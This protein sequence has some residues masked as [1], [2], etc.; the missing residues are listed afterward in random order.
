ML[1]A[2]TE[3]SE[4]QVDPIWAPEIGLALNIPAENQLW[5]GWWKSKPDIYKRLQELRSQHGITVQDDL[6]ESDV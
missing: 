6:G 5:P 4:D 1:I 2:Y 3:D